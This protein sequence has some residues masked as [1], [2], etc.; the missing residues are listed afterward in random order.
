M[1]PATSDAVF[2]S[3]ALSSPALSPSPAKAGAA[4]GGVII[5]DLKQGERPASMTAPG[6]RPAEV[7]PAGVRPPGVRPAG[8]TAWLPAALPT[9]VEPATPFGEPAGAAGARPRAVPRTARAATEEAHRF[10]AQAQVELGR[11]QAEAEQLRL[12]ARADATAAGELRRRAGAALLEAGEII[13]TAAEARQLLEQNRKQGAALLA[14]AAAEA[15]AA[16]VATFAA[17]QEE[18]YAAGQR[19]GHL[20]GVEIARA[21]LRDQLEIA[22]GIAAGAGVDRARLV[23]GAEVATIQIA[24]DVA[25]RVIGSQ[26]E[27][28]PHVL[29]DLFHRALLKAAGEDRIRLRL[30]PATIDCLGEA[31]AEVTARFAARGVDVVADPTVAETGVVVDTRA[32][33]VDAGVETQLARAEQTLLDLAG[34]G[35]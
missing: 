3:S 24:L 29:A 23:A 33:R 15:Q 10:L 5:K 4:G 26:I 34:E 14:G 7:R 32:G 2:S 30:H 17:A 8:V 16:S 25:R 6:V 28:A 13:T 35:R 9:V 11:A 21:E 20:A 1:T 12:T 19:T 18:G 22:H 31:L 27:A